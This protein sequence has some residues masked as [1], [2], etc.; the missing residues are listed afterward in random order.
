MNEPL[1]FYI[2]DKI[3]WNDVTWPLYTLTKY[4]FHLLVH[5]INMDIFT[6]MNLLRHQYLVIMHINI[7]LDIYLHSIITK[8][9]NRLCFIVVQLICLI[10][11][12]SSLLFL[13]H[14][15]GYFLKPDSLSVIQ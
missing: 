12:E 13:C 9:I 8:I 6:C 3:L 7:F 4:Y 1:K 11:A 2:S 15:F 10:S 5:I 14:T